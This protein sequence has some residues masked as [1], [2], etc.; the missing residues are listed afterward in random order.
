MSFTLVNNTASNLT[1]YSS[2]EAYFGEQLPAQ[3]LS[4]GSYVT[5]SIV[6]SFNPGLA[7]V[8]NGDHWM[9]FFSGSSTG[10]AII[11]HVGITPLVLNAN[12]H[13]A[14]YCLDN[15]GAP[16][17]LP[18][19]RIG[20]KFTIIGDDTELRIYFSVVTGGSIILSSGLPAAQLAPG[21][22]E[23]TGAD[24]QYNTEAGVLVNSDPTAL[25]SMI[26]LT[27]LGGGRWFVNL[28]LGSI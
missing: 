13:G 10:P 21:S 2:L 1:V 9:Q 20:T 17:G 16:I 27:S 28:L 8:G 5:S 7:L 18:D 25:L 4:N 23:F 26:E 22:T 24:T 6:R 3:I 11:Q 14:T 12:E 19:A 15:S